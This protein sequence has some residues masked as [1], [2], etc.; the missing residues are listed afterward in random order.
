MIDFFIFGWNFRDL[1]E[2]VC[3]KPSHN[4]IQRYFPSN[5][6]PHIRIIAPG[7]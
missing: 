5:N 2:Q 6:L 7:L 1:S 3:G 4:N